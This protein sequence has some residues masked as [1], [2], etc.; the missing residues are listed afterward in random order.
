MGTEDSL[1][2]TH[3]RTFLSP[4]PTPHLQFLTQSCLSS[5]FSVYLLWV[6]PSMAPIP[7]FDCQPVFRLQDSVAWCP[8]LFLPV[9]G[10]VGHAWRAHPLTSS[11][12]PEHHVLFLLSSCFWGDVGPVRGHTLLTPVPI[13][14]QNFP[15]H[16]HLSSLPN[17]EQRK[18]HTTHVLL[19]WTV[20]SISVESIHYNVLKWK[21]TK[22]K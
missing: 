14:P 11:L 16:N 19:K 15:L 3:P 5:L 17:H 9:R 6:F 21:G 20:Y 2:E 13:S 12:P 22:L 8:G 1:Q 4:P 10:Y 7:A 18:R